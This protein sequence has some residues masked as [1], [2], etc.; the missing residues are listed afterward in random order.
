MLFSIRM[1]YHKK[2]ES[3]MCSEYISYNRL[4]GVKTIKLTMDLQRVKQR[5]CG[6]FYANTVTTELNNTQL[7]LLI[8]VFK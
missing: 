6:R 7:M 3:F 1:L 4:P 8:I 2:T 5:Y